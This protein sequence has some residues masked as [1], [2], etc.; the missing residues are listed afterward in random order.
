MEFEYTGR[1]VDVTPTLRR[2]VEEHFSKLDHIFD[3]ATARAHIIIEVE[4]NRHMGEVLL[5]WR[6]E[7]MT[8]RD[9]NAD[10]YQ[11][12]TRAIAKIEKQAVKLKRKLI[13][14]RQGAR[15]LSSLAPDTGAVEPA[16]KP[17]GRI[18]NARRYS[19]K[20]MTAEEAA[21][22]LSEDDNQFL[23]FRDSENERIGVIYKR[24]DGN[25]GLIVP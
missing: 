12:L 20:P 7:T 10:M 2:H 21:M 9:V 11:A 13:D 23:V 8:A 14:R 18:I 1:H 6:G 22:R 16:A 24:K 15:P 3:D 17:D 5:H 19:I 4:K 25:Y